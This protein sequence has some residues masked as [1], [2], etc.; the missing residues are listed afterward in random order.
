MRSMIIM[1]TYNERENLPEVTRRILA[2]GLDLR[3]T[4]VDDNSPDRTGEVADDLARR[5]DCVRVIHRGRKLGLG[6][7]YIEGFQYALKQGMDY[8]L[9]MDADLSHDPSSLPRFLAALEQDDVVCGSRYVAGGGTSNWGLGRQFIS[10]GGSLYARTILGLPLHDCTGGFNAYRREV[11]EAIAPHTITSTGY[12]FQ[13]EL[14]YRSYRHG[15]R[16][17][18]VPIIFA[19]RRAGRS[20][21]ST[22]IFVEAM[23]KVWELRLGDLRRPRAQ[24]AGQA[25]QTER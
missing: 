12:S 19:D 22:A 9:Q 4:V 16:I 13:I 18:E 24:R 17:G 11:L 10:R 1:P 23:L 3:L 14:K 7:A 25:S 2:L 6:T 21:M 15:F 8:I 5:F 20:K